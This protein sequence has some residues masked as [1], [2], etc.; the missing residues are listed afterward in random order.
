MVLIAA[1]L[2][3]ATAPATESIM[4][5]LPP[6]KAGVGSAVNDTTRELGGTLGVA[7]LGS[8]FSSVYGPGLVDKL[9][10][11]PIPAPA[12]D[13]AKE[14]VGATLVVAERATAQA[15]PQAGQAVLDAARTTFVDGLGAA[16]LVA[17]AVVF[18]GAVLAA[19]FLPAR[20]RSA[21]A[22]ELDEVAEVD[23][24]AGLAGVRLSPSD[25]RRKSSCSRSRFSATTSCGVMWVTPDSGSTR[26]GRPA[27]RSADDSCSVWATTTLSSARPWMS[28]SGR[29]GR[30]RPRPGDL[31]DERRAV[32]HLGLGL[33]RAEVALGVVRVVQAPVGHRR[34][35][36]GGVEDVRPAE[37]GQRGQVATE[38]PPADRHA[39]EVEL[40]VLL[41]RG[42]QGVDLVLEDRCG[43]VEVDGPLPG[44][45]PARGA[46]AVGHDDGEALVGEPLRRV[47]GG[48]GGQH[49]LRV[50][51]AVRIEQHGERGG[52]RGPAVPGQEHRGGDRPAPGPQ[53]RDRR[54]DQRRLGVVGDLR[55]TQ[56]PGDAAFALERRR[57]DDHRLAAAPAG[58]DTGLHDERFGGGTVAEP[59]ETHTRCVC[60]PGWR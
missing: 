20:A 16:S 51:A 18:A 7:V 1:G 43:E 13:A 46:A 53:Q 9:G 8:V 32:V 2:G 4:G 60:Q 15:G 33:G 35:G 42:V 49:P 56:H 41:R 28:S 50:R 34:P 44:A 6:E 5:S 31:G 12:L 26:C 48:A 29:V 45:A 58:V 38:A 11:L 37:H 14:S 52:V 40:R 10:G 21:G 24:T 25:S 36:D 57:P 27:A 19:L 30:P 59:P 3:L 23:H 39:G 54:A 17:A 55:P 47:V 22:G